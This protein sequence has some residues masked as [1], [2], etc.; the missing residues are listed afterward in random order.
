MGVTL[1]CAAAN[2]LTS[3]CRCVRQSRKDTLTRGGWAERPTLS[4]AD[5]TTETA[6]ETETNAAVHI[7][8]TSDTRWLQHGWL[9]RA[10]PDSS[11]TPIPNS[12]SAAAAHCPSVSPSFPRS[13]LGTKQLSQYFWLRRGRGRRRQQQIAIFNMLLQPEGG[14]RSRRDGRRRGRGLHILFP[15]D[16]WLRGGEEQ[17]RKSSAVSSSKPTNGREGGSRGRRGGRLWPHL[18]VCLS[19]SSSSLLFLLQFP[20]YTME[21]RSR[22]VRPTQSRSRSSSC[23]SPVILD[24]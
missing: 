4:L 2:I 13:E 9:A 20:V 23:R 10:G 16:R 24:T 3:R 17:S 22:S 8:N 21:R 1:Y 5:V 18:R 14:R 15:S 11:S 6:S 12:K 19:F 7:H